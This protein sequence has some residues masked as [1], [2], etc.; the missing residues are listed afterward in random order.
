MTTEPLPF[1]GGA[2]PETPDAPCIGHWVTVKDDDRVGDTPGEIINHIDNCG[3]TFYFVAFRDD[4]GFMWHLGK[5][6]QER[7]T[8]A[9]FSKPTA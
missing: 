8:F 1:D 6:P 3:V 9:G 4:D 7:M 2:T 5:Y